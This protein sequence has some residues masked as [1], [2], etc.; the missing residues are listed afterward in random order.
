MLK[1]GENQG[2]WSILLEAATTWLGLLVH[3]PFHTAWLSLFLEEHYLSSMSGSGQ[4][5]RRR[6][7]NAAILISGGDSSDEDDNTTSTTSQPVLPE[8]TLP[9]LYSRVLERYVL[10]I[11]FI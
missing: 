6:I 1:T 8:D 4:A 7:R 3:W 5:L 2:N 10:S 9:M 11:Y